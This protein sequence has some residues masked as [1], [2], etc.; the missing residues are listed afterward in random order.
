MYILLRAQ[1]IGIDPKLNM[2]HYVYCTHV[3]R[4]CVCSEGLDIPKVKYKNL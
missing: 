1:Y 2:R 3:V 4:D